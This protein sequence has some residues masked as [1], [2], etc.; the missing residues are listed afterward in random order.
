MALFHDR[1]LAVKAAKSG[2]DDRT[3]NDQPGTD[4]EHSVNES[5]FI[6]VTNIAKAIGR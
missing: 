5:A 4:G 3:N 6:A 2:R 1:L